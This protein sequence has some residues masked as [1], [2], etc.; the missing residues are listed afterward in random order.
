MTFVQDSHESKQQR[1][2]QLPD[3]KI[4]IVN[5]RG[6]V[7]EVKQKD[8]KVYVKRGF[9]LAPKGAVLGEYLPA[10][11]RGDGETPVTKTEKPKKDIPMNALEVIIL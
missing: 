10:F 6:R 3:T 2:N 11:D 4:L 5:P 9:R 1:Y 7:V 8:A